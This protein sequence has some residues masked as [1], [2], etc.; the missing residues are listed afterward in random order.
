MSRIVHGFR[1][2]YINERQVIIEKGQ[3]PDGTTALQV[4]SPIGEPLTTAT[5]SLA[6]YGEKPDA[7]NVFIYGDYSEHVGV[8]EALHKAGVIGNAVRIIEIGGHGA[9]AYECPLLVEV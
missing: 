6:H 2:K 3:Y 9:E 8:F 7:G 4:K 1:T 5:V